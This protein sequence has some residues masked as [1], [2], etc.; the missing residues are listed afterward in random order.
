M[1]FGPKTIA[2]VEMRGLGINHN[3]ATN[4]TRIRLLDAQ[5]TSVWTTSTDDGRRYGAACD[6]APAWLDGNGTGPAALLRAM[7]GACDDRATRSGQRMAGNM[8][9]L[10]DALREAAGSLAPAAQT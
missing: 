10:A 7:A 3:R 6:S 4:R 5:E 9:R 8:R 1:K 2:A